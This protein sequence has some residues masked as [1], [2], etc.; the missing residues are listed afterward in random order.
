MIVCICRG[1]SSR[2][3]QRHANQAG[4]WGA[5]IESSPCGKQCGKCLL[6][7]KDIY[8]KEVCGKLNRASDGPC[9]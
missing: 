5:F 9:Q 1:V 6:E 3:I 7:A 4:D 8:C 2:D